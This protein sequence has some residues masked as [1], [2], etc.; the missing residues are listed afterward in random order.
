MRKTALFYA[1]GIFVWSLALGSAVSFRQA[2]PA[3]ISS[4]VLQSADFR[5]GSA[6][7]QVSVSIP[8]T[9]VNLHGAA[10]RGHII[11]IR[12]HRLLARG[13]EP[14]VP[15]MT[16]R[17]ILPGNANVTGVNLARPEFAEIKGRLHVAPA[18]WPMQLTGGP[19]PGAGEFREDIYTR[20][21]FYPGNALSYV[22]G[23]DGRNTIVYLRFYPVQYNPVT[24]LAVIITDAALEVHYDIE[25]APAPEQRGSISPAENIIITTSS[26][27]APAESLRALH[28]D[29]EGLTTDVV[30]V[31]WIDSTYTEAEDPL[32]PGYANM[33]GGPVSG[34]YDYALARKVVSFLR[35]AAAHP[36]L[37]SVTV[38][39]DALEVP[40]SYYFYVP[41][42]TEYNNWIP[43]DL[44]YGSPDYDMALNYRV[45]RLPVSTL[46]EA[47][48]IVEKYA[49]WKSGL[50]PGWFHNAAVFGGA[51]FNTLHLYG[52]MGMV[53]ALENGCL[54][55]HSVEKNYHSNFR[56]H[57]DVLIPHFTDEDTGI[58]FASGH[59]SGLSYIM[60]TTTMHSSEFA[61]MSPTSRHPLLF[62][63]ACLNG[64]YDA[65]L[66]PNGYSRCYGERAL[67]S[68]AGPIAF[69]GSS[70]T[71]FV[72]YD[73][74]FD[75]SGALAV[76]GS[77]YL[78][79]VMINCLKAYSGGATSLGE[80]AF[81]AF[82]EYM[83]IYEPENY[84][85]RVTAYEYIFLGD[86][87]FSVPPAPS[88][89]PYDNIR[90]DAEPPPDEAGHGFDEPVYYS[91]S[92]FSPTVTL[93]GE[94]DSPAVTMRICRLT[95][96]LPTVTEEIYLTD[97]TPPF[98]CDF[99]PGTEGVFLA[100]F[101]TEGGR[102][103]RLYFRTELTG[104]IPPTECVLR[105]IIPE[106]DSYH[107]LWSPSFDREG[108]S[109]SYALRELANPSISQDSCDSIDNWL[110][111]GF[112]VSAGGLGGTD[113]FWSGKGNSLNNTIT[114]P[115]AVEIEEGDSLVFCKK[116]FIEDSWDCAYAEVSADGSDFTTL[117]KYTG[118]SSAWTRSA[119]DLSPYAGDSLF[120][121]F[122]YTTDFVI[123]KDGFYLD[124]IAPA[125][126]FEDITSIEGLTDTTY[127]APAAAPAG[128]YCY[129]VRALDEGGAWSDWSGVLGI[130]VDNAAIPTGDTAG[131][132]PPE[133]V[134]RANSPNPF[135]CATG[136]IFG[137]ATP[138]RVTVD[139]YSPA[140]RL[141]RNLARGHLGAGWHSL[142]WDGKD[143]GGLPV[144]P[145]VYFL[146]MQ[147]SDFRFTRKM[148]RLR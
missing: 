31:E 58:I 127:Q 83:L 119:I 97:E 63:V 142:H 104:N 28:M 140:G 24:A 67:A 35:D 33:S 46:E 38:L 86:P 30:T 111:R 48:H 96:G 99:T 20:D 87:A 109:I 117:E 84:V 4:L 89:T 105:A 14:S 8:E 73:Y 91:T 52:E 80:I 122:R 11:S 79:G 43:S 85:D 133:N 2:A 147:T 125:I 23:S 78:S 148:V 106:G 17:V 41:Q 69:W 7:E 90:L 98:T 60:T 144:A 102:E 134:L 93:S 54:E 120:I 129:Q 136:V 16:M 26:L 75:E 18:H 121:R 9:D 62:M 21:A 145:G 135:R 25:P 22:S 126:W 55:G 116:Y 137:L 3:H 27:L 59:G 141:V 45:G 12:G 118:T 47:E 66:V 53:Y 81:E 138:G 44:F 15:V 39:G 100:S 82:D 124:N 113:C 5:T 107:V 34:P 64:S 131:A 40:P 51:T 92:S 10:E 76:A 95:P 110:S 50:D 112:A 123:A 1:L 49:S 77:R 72:G 139:V 115:V 132:L 65:E 56:E 37:V 101:E 74:S 61:A 108:G 13:G 88:P 70:R 143:A 68:P 36:D 42:Y 130:V 114:T 128:H 71:A 103:T 146:H 32:Q 94:T 57:R 6:V 19:Q 29:M